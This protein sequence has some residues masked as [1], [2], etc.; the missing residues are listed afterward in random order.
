MFMAVVH[1]YHWRNCSFDITMGLQTGNWRIYW[2]FI[3]TRINQYICFIY[4][5]QNKAM[6]QNFKFFKLCTHRS[7]TSPFILTPFIHMWILVSGFILYFV[8]QLCRSFEECIVVRESYFGRNYSNE[9]L[10]CLIFHWKIIFYV[11][12][13][14]RFLIPFSAVFNAYIACVYHN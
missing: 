5:L 13:E 3:V 8:Q 9:S 12:K 1:L 4:I 6:V 14:F 11:P 7:L 10:S 2:C